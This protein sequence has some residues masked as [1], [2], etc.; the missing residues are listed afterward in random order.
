M[1]ADPKIHEE[2]DWPAKFEKW[3]SLISLSTA[4][5]KKLRAKDI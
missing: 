2:M 1:A 5:A 3:Q 4:L